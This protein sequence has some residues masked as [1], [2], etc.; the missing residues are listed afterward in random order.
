MVFIVPLL[1]A[2]GW[3][4]FDD[5]DY[6]VSSEEDEGALDFTLR[7][8][9]PIGIEAKALDVKPPEDLSH[10]QITKG[11][12]QAQARQADYFI[13]TNGDCWQ[14]YSLALSNAPI[15]GLTLSEAH[16]NQERIEQIADELDF[17]QKESFR[18]NPDLFGEAIREKWR[19]AVLPAALDTFLNERRHDLVQLFQSELPSELAIR[20]DEILTFLE[21][22]RTPR[23]SA[24]PVKKRRKRGRSLLSF[25]EDWQALLDSFEP[26]YER[27]R[28]RFSQ[29]YYRRLA[30]YLVG[31]RYGPWSKSTTWRN[32]G[33]PNTTNERKKLGPVMSLFREWHLIEEAPQDADKYQRVEEGMPYLRKL[34]DESAKT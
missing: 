1:E 24:V 11:L 33:T 16:G 17:L 8:Q 3:D 31:D 4:R 19:M 34:I 14:F 26:Q 5:M 18:A 27:A 6:E 20:D 22:L 2:L 23:D 13:W 29:T 30:E 9:Q 10:S 15:Y 21:D 25:P 28:E 32:V 12:E 7:G